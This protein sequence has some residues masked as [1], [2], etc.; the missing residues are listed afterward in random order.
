MYK[1]FR[2]GLCAIILICTLSMHSGCSGSNKQAENYDSIEAE[3][4]S[5]IC[6]IVVGVN[7]S[8]PFQE[9]VYTTMVGADVDTKQ[10][11]FVYKYEVRESPAKRNIQGFRDVTIRELQ[12]NLDSIGISRILDMKNN[13][14]SKQFLDILCKHNYGIEFNYVGKESNDTARLVFSN[15]T[16]RAV[17]NYTKP[18]LK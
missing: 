6:E 2:Y 11:L 5:D 15:D 12:H 4:P 8:C 14:E 1:K 3:Y 13:P 7:Q 16:I 17:V 10:R 18:V 9:D